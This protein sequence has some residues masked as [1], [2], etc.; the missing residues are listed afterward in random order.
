[1]SKGGLDHSESVR[2]VLIEKNAAE[3]F[4]M[5]TFL[6]SEALLYQLEVLSDGADARQFFREYSVT[7]KPIPSL[8]LLELNLPKYDGF[9]V[10]KTI[11]E[12]PGLSQLR[13]AVLTH[14]IDPNEAAA[15]SR[16]RL[17]FVRLKPDTVEGFTQLAR[18]ISEYAR[19]EWAKRRGAG[20]VS[21]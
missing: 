4:L 17:C 1:M 19:Q 20:Y 6:D 7:E 14:G 15:L 21:R 8:V 5:R 2:I 10:L 13:V 18:E 3:V 9:E 12:T 16:F 11:Q